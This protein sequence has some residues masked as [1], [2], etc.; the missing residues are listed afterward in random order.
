MNYL[1]LTPIFTISLLA[2]SFSACAQSQYTSSCEKINGKPIANSLQEM[3]DQA[4]FI[5]LF[6][7]ES[8]NS[9]SIEPRIANYQYPIYSYDLSLS[10]AIKGTP[11][12]E[13]N[14]PVYF[15]TKTV[16][17]E[18]FYIKD[19]HQNIADNDHPVLGFSYMVKMKSGECKYSTQLVEGYEYLVFGG[20][21]SSSVYQPILDQRFDPFYRKVRA[22]LK[23]KGSN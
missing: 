1:F 4:E 14:I 13:Y 10:K 23:K 15:E 22:K 6:E 12:E 16:P 20:A 18:Y 8:Y 19:I 2:L 11:P 7:V 17:A 9:K 3:I 21:N 5:A